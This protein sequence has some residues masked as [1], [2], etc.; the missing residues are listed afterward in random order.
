[1]N[2]FVAG[3]ARLLMWLIATAAGLVLFASLLLATLVLA[4]A[5]GL[6]AGWARLTGRPVNPWVMRMDPRTGFGTVFRS[7]RWSATAR[8]GPVA[9]DE[10]GSAAA[11]SRRGGVLPGAQEVT[12]V[13]ARQVR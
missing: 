4:A 5:W 8:S 6:R 2:D 1:M 3:I 10:A 12:D 11:P 9:P 7:A 13:E